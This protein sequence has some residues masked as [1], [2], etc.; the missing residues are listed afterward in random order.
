MFD[1]PEET[2]DEPIIDPA[3][4]AKDRSDEFRM[5]AELCAVFEGTRKFE[6]Q[7]L[8]DLSPELARDLQKTIGKLEKLKLP[9]TP[10]ISPDGMADAARL[11]DLPH[12]AGIS[13]NDYHVYHRPGE[14]MIARFLSGEQVETFYQRLQAHCDAALT[15]FR[16]DER[17]THEWKQDPQTLKY[18]EALEKLEIKME[19]RYLR[20]MIRQHQLYVLSTQAADELNI[21]HLSDYI[22]GA[23]AAEL[24]GSAS[25]PSDDPMA[26][27]D[28]AP[29]DQAWFFKL[30]S[31][32]GLKQGEE[33]MCFFAYLQKAD[34]GW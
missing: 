20:P 18:L 15:Q 17:S 5:H 2:P 12:A 19:D 9:E 29:S 26:E 16:D 8:P 33:Q 34:D 27:N 23:S 1:E 31:L 7:I 4:R 11:L 3:Q 24:V 25:A 30:F 13:T 22:M 28:E 6:A 32:R 14:T 10:V 21:A